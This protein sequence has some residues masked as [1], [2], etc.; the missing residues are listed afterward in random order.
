ME[1]DASDPIRFLREVFHAF[2][3][4]VVS[5]IDWDAD[6]ASS[7]SLILPE[8]GGIILKLKTTATGLGTM[9]HI[10]DRLWK[11]MKVHSPKR[12]PCDCAPSYTAAHNAEV[13][14]D[15]CFGN[16]DA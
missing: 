14:F 2:Q 1:K 9:T 15:A 6:F 3:N 12:S 10:T 16:A 4:D 8:S 5:R 11:S 13:L 7:A